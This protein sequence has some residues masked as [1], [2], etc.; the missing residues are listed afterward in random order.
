MYIQIFKA[1]L[2]IHIYSILYKD[3]MDRLLLGL[4]RQTYDRKYI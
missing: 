2:W 1:I 4:V 3:K